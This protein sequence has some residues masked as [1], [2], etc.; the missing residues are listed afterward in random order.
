MPDHGRDV[1]FGYF[2]VPDV[3]EPLVATAQEVERLGLDYVGV[4]GW[5]RAGLTAGRRRSPSPRKFCGRP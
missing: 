5:W 1:K 2:L 4:Q 3:S